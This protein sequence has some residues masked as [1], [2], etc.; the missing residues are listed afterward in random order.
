MGSIADARR[1]G[2]RPTTAP[3]TTTSSPTALNV[4]ESAGSR[5]NNNPATRRP[6]VSAQGMPR[7]TPSSVRTSPSARIRHGKRTQDERVQKTVNRCVRTHSEDQHYEYVES[8]G[9][10][11][12]KVPNSTADILPQRFNHARSSRDTRSATKNAKI[13]CGDASDHGQRAKIYLNRSQAYPDQCFG[14]AASA[15]RALSLFGLSRNTA[16]NCSAASRNLPVPASA[17]PKFI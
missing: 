12:T 10:G 17:T 1:A 7:A 13:Q 14:L 4:A 16:L 5:P 8:E 2:R 11:I 6:P 3:R 9:A 15:R